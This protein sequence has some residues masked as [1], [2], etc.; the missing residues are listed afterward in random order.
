MIL[1]FQQSLY[2]W[3]VTIQENIEIIY[4]LKALRDAYCDKVIISDVKRTLFTGCPNKMITSSSHVHFLEIKI[5]GN[6][7]TIKKNLDQVVKTL[8]KEDRNQYLLPFSNWLAHFFKNS[9][10]TP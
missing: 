1:I 6:H 4:T 10:L 5:Y 2:H 9:H 3:G 8:N 7:T